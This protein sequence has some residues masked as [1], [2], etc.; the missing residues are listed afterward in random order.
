MVRPSFM[1]EVAIAKAYLPVKMNFCHLFI[2]NK[3]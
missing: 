2:Y 1:F 3:V